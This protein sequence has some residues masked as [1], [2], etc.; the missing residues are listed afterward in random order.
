VSRMGRGAADPRLS[1]VLAA[2]SV[3]VILGLAIVTAADGPRLLSVVGQVALL[4]AFGGLVVMDLR[5]AA[6][7]ALIELVLGGSSGQWTTYPG[8]I[9][10]RIVLD[11]LV[12]ARALA[13]LIASRNGSWRDMF[14]RYGWHALG[15][16]ILL[17]GIWM[18]LGLVN[19]NLPHDVVSD[20]NAQAFFAFA[21]VFIALVRMGDGAWLRRWL[22]VA[23]SLNAMLIGALALV[24]M[25]GFVEMEPTLRV[26]L[27]DR[28]GMGNSIG[29]LPNGAYRLFLAN[30]LF[31][32]VGV[33]ATTW[34]LL[35]RRTSPGLW[36]LLVLLGYDLVASYTRGFWIGAIIAFAIVI[37]LGAASFRNAAAVVLGVVALS[38]AATAVGLIVGFSLPDYLLQ[39]TASIV[40]SA[41]PSAAPGTTPAPVMPGV[42]PPPPVIPGKDTSGEVSNSVRVEQARVLFGHIAERPVLGW[43][44]GSIAPDYRYGTIPSYELAYLDLAF[45]TGLIGLLLWLSWSARIL[46]DLG[47]GRF[48]WLSLPDGVDPRSLSLPIAM[49]VSV[50]V[51]GATNPY[52]LASYG[53]LS[54]LW[55]IA[56]LE[57]NPNREDRLAGTMIHAA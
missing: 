23:C 35:Q 22:F 57:R 2:V 54:L 24:S 32:Q 28:L 38:F 29:Y 44:F 46:F 18:P 49:M 47:R 15:L 8:S 30:G 37:V 4:V 40:T 39:R 17:I 25:L 53:M 26:I 13:Y 6:A 3:A 14:G 20:G 19:G 56:W 45:K 27:W 48:H 11:A 33:A 36:A 43:G 5:T 9:H 42:A 12:A 41:P 1:Q 21:L 34:E 16:A 55:G 50:L 7:I 10:G 52:V 31:L 51:T